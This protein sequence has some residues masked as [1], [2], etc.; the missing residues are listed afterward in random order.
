MA[1]RQ[2]AFLRHLRRVVKPP[3]GDEPGDRQLLRRFTDQRSEAAFQD[4]VR[5]HGPL[6]Y[7]VC[8]RV[9]SRE[10]DVEDAFQATFLV[11]AEKA[12]SIRKQESLA[13]W[14]YGVA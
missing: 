1:A 14:L 2:A 8:R 9:L 10:H 7:G 12:A 5:R 3:P 11:L 6:V 4:L 13:C